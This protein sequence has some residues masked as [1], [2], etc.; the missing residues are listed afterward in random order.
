MLTFDTLREANKRRLPLFKNKHGQPAHM[1]ADGSDWDFET[2]LMA[3]I[4][5]LGEAAQVRIDL[6]AQHISFGTYKQRITDELAD[7]ATYLDILA[8]RS[9]DMPLQDEDYEELEKN[10]ATQDHDPYITDARLMMLCMSLLGQVANDC[11]K[12]YRGDM[13]SAEYQSRKK[14]LVKSLLGSLTIL[15]WSK[16]VKGQPSRAVHAD[17][18]NL[19]EAV[20]NKFNVVSDR[21]GAPI[22]IVK[23][24]EDSFASYAGAYTIE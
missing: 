17:G 23:K 15:Q 14:D 10:R 6:E 24:H 18:V 16:G 20:V 5:E 19:G 9:L 22:K 8:L 2:W 21:V 11:K 4:G 1:R 13:T 3:T 7:T 12:L